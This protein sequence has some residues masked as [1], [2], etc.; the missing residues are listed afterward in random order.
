MSRD[1]P[2]LFFF[3]RV[4]GKSCLHASISRKWCDLEAVLMPT[5]CLFFRL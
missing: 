5:C 1:S 2:V 3:R 4:F